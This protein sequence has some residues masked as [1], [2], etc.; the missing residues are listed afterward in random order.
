MNPEMFRGLAVAFI[1]AAFIGLMGCLF[2]PSGTLAASEPKEFRRQ[3]TTGL[4]STVY[5][6]EP[7]FPLGWTFTDTQGRRVESTRLCDYTRIK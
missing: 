6:A 7:K 5:D 3:C 4:Y 1:G 2:A